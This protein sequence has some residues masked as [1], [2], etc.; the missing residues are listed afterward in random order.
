MLLTM[1]GEAII[2]ARVKMMNCLIVGVDMTLSM[3][4]LYR[5]H[6]EAEVVAGKSSPE[7]MGVFHTTGRH[8]SLWMMASGKTKLI[9]TIIR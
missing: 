8:V 9:T 6:L 2:L 7:Q 1:V 4:G 5:M 3:V